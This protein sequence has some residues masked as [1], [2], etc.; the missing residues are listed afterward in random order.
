MNADGTELTRL[1]ND[2]GVDAFPAWSPDG[3]RIAFQPDRT[4]NGDIYSIDIDGSGLM[5]LTDDR[6][7]DG[8]P[9]WSP[10]GRWIAFHS[11]RNGDEGEFE[12]YVMNFDGSHE[13]RL[14]HDSETSNRVTT[15]TRLGP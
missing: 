9:A 14:T 7:Q 15:R 12:I 1:T 10:D 4:G 8:A 3:R 13:T 5:R 11:D 6:G 2:S